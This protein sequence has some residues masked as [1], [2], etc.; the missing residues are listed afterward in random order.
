MPIKIPQLPS[1]PAGTITGQ[2]SIPVSKTNSDPKT[3]KMSLSQA[4]TWIQ[5]NGGGG[6]GGTGAQGA[7]GAQG[8][9]GAQGTAGTPGV[10]GASGYNG[11][12]GAQG[13]PGLTGSSGYQGLVGPQ[14]F[15]GV[16]GYQGFQ[17]SMGSNTGTPGPGLVYT[18]Y[19]KGTSATY[20]NFDVR[21]DV[22]SYSGVGTLDYYY[23]NSTTL[24]ATSGASGWGVPGIDSNWSNFGQNFE[25]VATGLL[26]TQDAAVTKTITLGEVSNLSAGIIRS[27]NC[28]NFFDG[29]GFWLGNDAQGRVGFFVGNSNGP[30]YLAYD[31]SV[32]AVALSGTIYAV[33]SFSATSN[34]TASYTEPLVTITTQNSASFADIILSNIEP[35]TGDLYKVKTLEDMISE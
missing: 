21:K 34:F 35:A 18:G 14:G 15:T 7:A 5:A 23:A 31:S 16:S 25:S 24:T 20:Y 13:S 11:V 30:S 8:A 4:L 32:G 6:G 3:Y 26:L 2:T 27:A 33:D 1:I 28:N 19:Y 10:Q 9:G 17:G 22:V 12:N 29:N